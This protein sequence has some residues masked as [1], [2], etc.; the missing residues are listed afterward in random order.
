MNISLP[1]EQMTVEE[2]LQMMEAIWDDLSQNAD[3]IQ[4]PSWHGKVLEAMELAIE[5]GEE[6]FDDWETAK[7]RIRDSVG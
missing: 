4:P 7:Q 2:K 3:E 5:R 6:T 1:L